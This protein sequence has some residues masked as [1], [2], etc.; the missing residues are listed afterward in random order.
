[1]AMT[2]HKKNNTDKSHHYLK[3]KQ[4]KNEHTKQWHIIQTLKD[5][6]NQS[7]ADKKKEATSAMK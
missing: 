7:A 5:N 1:M 6:K 2:V 3:N 4:T